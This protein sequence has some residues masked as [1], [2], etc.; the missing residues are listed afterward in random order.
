MPKSNIIFKN[1]RRLESNTECTLDSILE[2]S[3][4]SSIGCTCICVSC[5]SCVSCTSMVG[6]DSTFID[7][8]LVDSAFI[9]SVPASSV[10]SLVKSL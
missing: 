4:V 1:R 9:D 5:F 3:L 10:E 8:I 7:F 2:S 6:L